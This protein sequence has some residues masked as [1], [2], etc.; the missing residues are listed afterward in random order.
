M[1]KT[2]VLVVTPRANL[3]EVGHLVQ[4]DPRIPAYW[5]YLPYL[6]CV[7][8]EM[9]AKELAELFTDAAGSGFLVV[10]IDT[11]NM[12]GK[13]PR[14]AWEWFREPAEAEDALAPGFREP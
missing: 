1:Y 3:D 10:E 8:T 6:F 11:S 7:K 9:S 14:A 13:L 12:N 4:T 5:N 2:Y